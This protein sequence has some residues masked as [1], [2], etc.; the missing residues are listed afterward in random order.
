METKRSVAE[1]GCVTVGLNVSFFGVRGS[2]PCSSPDLHRIGGN[3]SCVVLQRDGEDPIVCDLGTGLRFYGVGINAFSGTLL[4]SH[5]H[6]DHIQGLPFFPPLLNPDS[7]IDILGP[8]QGDV[9]FGEAFNECIRPPYFPIELAELAH[10]ANFIDFDNAIRTVGSATITARP[11]PHNGLTN[12]YRI[13]WDDFTVAYVPD[14]QQPIHDHDHVA[15]SVLE[16]ARDADL[17]IHDAQFTPELLT[18]R[19]N[20]GHCTPGY[21]STVARQAGAK[22]LALFHHDP[23]HGDDTVESLAREADAAAEDVEVFAASENQPLRY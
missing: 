22:R 14:H 4:V 9:S 1:G 18:V 13:S 20:W 6:W 17:L 10:H 2:T 3:T 19:P 23:L 15:D 21:A 7:K 16:L 8:P 5:L 11:V 12:G